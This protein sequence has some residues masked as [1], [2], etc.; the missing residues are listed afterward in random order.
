REKFETDPKNQWLSRGPSY[1]LCGEAIRD[2]ALLAAGLLV[3]KSGGPSVK[4]WQPAGIW[5][6]AGASGGD[7][8]PDAGEGLHRRSLYTFRKRT[9]PPPS[10]LT[11]DAGS[12]E[13]CQAR[14]LTTNTPLQPLIFLNDQ[15]Y[16]ECAR[17]LAKRVASEP[18]DAPDTP[19]KQA[20]LRLTSRLPA[21]PE[22]AALRDL[23]AR[24]LKHF[25]ADLPATKAVSGE[26][27]PNLAA[28]VIVCST[29]LTCDATLTNR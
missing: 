26:D 9:A 3:E 12:R 8:Q 29:L 15:G 21:A 7:Y 13:I 17:A 23:H 22:L 28:L 19:L 27:N 5:S 18:A 25:T 10:L 16:F 4:P 1:R 14:R 2:Q 20:F 11:L 6:E 24:E